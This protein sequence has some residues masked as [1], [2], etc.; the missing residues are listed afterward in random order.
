MK[1]KKYLLFDADNTLYDFTA[2]EKAALKRLFGKYSISESLYPVYHRGNA[3]CWARYEK[4]E[5]TLEALETERFRLFAEAAGLTA[6]PAAMGN[7][8]AAMLGEEGI[9]IPGAVDFLGKIKGKYS[10]SIITNGIARVQRERI[11]RTGTESFYDS[12][13]ISQEIG[14]AKP[15]TRFFDFVLNALNASKESCLV[16]GD[17]LSSDI[18]GANDAGID[19]VL[20]SFSGNASS[21]A[22]W[23]VSSY[24]ELLSLLEN[25][26]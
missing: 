3:E 9:M 4:G 21:D 23:S 16:I 10:L 15:D 25:D 2:T 7:V 5:L 13:F 17:S 24:N 6:D 18:K 1:G 22:T 20:I 14:Y 8:Y 11:R 12:I 19:S 26:A